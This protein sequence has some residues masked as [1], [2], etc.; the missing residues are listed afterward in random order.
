MSALHKA[1]NSN[2]DL[3]KSGI[4]LQYGEVVRDGKKVPVTITIARAGGSNTRFDKVFEVKTKPYKRLIQSDALDK[5]VS[6]KIMR[7]V[8]AE[9]VILGWENVQNNEDE[10]LPFNK[11]NVITILTELPDL[12]DDIAAQASKASLFRDEIIEADSKN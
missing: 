7:E 1:F 12:F 8:Y 2:K 10:F 6:K 5:E 11:E 3:E 9:T 4:L